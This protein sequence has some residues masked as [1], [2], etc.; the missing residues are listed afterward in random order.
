DRGRELVDARLL[1]GLHRGA[2]APELAVDGGVEVA[3][4]ERAAAE[5]SHPVP[6]DADAPA[7]RGPQ[8]PEVEASPSTVEAGEEVDDRE[9]CDHGEV[10]P[11]VAMK[12]ELG[13]GATPRPAERF[14][15]RREWLLG[16]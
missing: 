8:E 14:L 11:Q 2:L 7:E 12:A 4:L 1:L 15:L 3:L 6:E 9:Q 13:S 16:L 5:H 10:R